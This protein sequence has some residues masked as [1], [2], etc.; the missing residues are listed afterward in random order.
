[1]GFVRKVDDWQNSPVTLAEK[2]PWF[3][4]ASRR[5]RWLIGVSGGADSVALL[6]LLVGSGFRNLV[7]CHLDH[8][9]RGRAS[10][11]DS[12]FVRRLADQLG[13]DCE[14]ARADVKEL[15]NERSESLETA[16]RNARLAFFAECAKKH[17]CPRIL[18]A[19][20]ADDQAETVLWNLLRGSHG[21]KGMRKSRKLTA[22]ESVGLELIRPLLEIRRED[23]IAWLKSHGHRW[24]EDASNAEPIAIRN[25]LRHEAL[26]LLGEISGRDAVSALARGASETEE[27]EA[28]EAWALDQAKVLDPQGRLHLP[29]L[30]AL[31]VA[32]QRIALR[33]FLQEGGVGSIDRELIERGLGLLDVGN[34]AAIN[35]PGGGTLRRREARL[36]IEC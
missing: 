35:L 23:L 24:R 15:M 13:L 14:M 3:S 5:R 10:T 27:A 36:R 20:H 6:H 7:V 12:K 25:R 17:R 19:H 31:P 30:R 11:G 4:S 34:P 26:P 32:L 22:G 18:L 21:L 1:M 33:K 29:V 8:G 28:L 16:A 2:I 9:L